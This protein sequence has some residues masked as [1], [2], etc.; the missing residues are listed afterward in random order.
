[1]LLSMTRAVASTLVFILL[2]SIVRMYNSSACAF[3]HHL[4]QFKS[5]RNPLRL[6][7]NCNFCVSS[8][9]STQQSSQNESSGSPEEFDT[10]R[11]RIWRQLADGK[12]LSVSQLSS[13]VGLRNWGELR[14]HLTHVEKQAKTIRNKSNDWK[15]RRG[16]PS[17]T[18]RKMKLQV[19]KGKKNK[20]YVRII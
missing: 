12:E 16:L 3:Q 8:L 5:S 17:D 7:I 9:Q 20:T 10:I 11:V 15:I 4:L 14:F 6:H 1:M 19:R 13:A 18:R 2:E